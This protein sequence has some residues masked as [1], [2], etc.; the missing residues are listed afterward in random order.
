VLALLG[1]LGI[2]RAVFCGMSQGGFLSLRAALL[3]PQRV[4]GLVL[5]D[6]EAGPGGG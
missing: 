3:A 4:C 5:I 6:S 1:H 2:E